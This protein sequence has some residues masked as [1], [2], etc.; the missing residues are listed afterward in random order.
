MLQEYENWKKDIL[1]KPKKFSLGDR[2]C[3]TSVRPCDE[4]FYR[5]GNKGT[6]VG[7][8]DEEG[9]GDTIKNGEIFQIEILES[10]DIRYKVGNRTTN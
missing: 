8:D 10:L 4:D 5:V 7:I 6:I 1:K 9:F 2:I 3:V